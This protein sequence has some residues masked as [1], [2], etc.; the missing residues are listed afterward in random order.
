MSLLNVNRAL[1][2]G[3][4]PSGNTNQHENPNCLFFV[5]LAALFCV[6]VSFL[7]QKCD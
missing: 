7:V 5:I 3:L 2:R 4:C 6:H 1:F